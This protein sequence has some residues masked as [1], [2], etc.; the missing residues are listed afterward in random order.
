MWGI[1]NQATNMSQ[2]L[3]HI[4]NFWIPRTPESWNN[5]A[6][7]QPV[8]FSVYCQIRILWL[9]V[10]GKLLKAY[11]SSLWNK[12]NYYFS[13]HICHMFKSDDFHTQSSLVNN[14]VVC[15]DTRIDLSFLHKLKNPFLLPTV[16]GALIS[17]YG[18]EFLEL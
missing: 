8:D 15:M 7:A 4:T 5:F 17:C 2:S 18:H 6:S 11:V 1:L 14:I 9:W 12:W 13:Y 3:A 16:A 10:S